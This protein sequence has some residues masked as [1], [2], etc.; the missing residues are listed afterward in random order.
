[1][2]FQ[3]LV[4]IW[5]NRSKPITLIS[6]RFQSESIEPRALLVRILVYTC[7]NDVDDAQAVGIGFQDSGLVWSSIKEALVAGPGDSYNPLSNTSFLGI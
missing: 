7:N 6:H 4:E 2:E 3:D 1:M 5:L